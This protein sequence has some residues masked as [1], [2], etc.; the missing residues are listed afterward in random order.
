[1]AAGP[2]GGDIVSVE[3]TETRRSASGCRSTPPRRVPPTG[4]RCAI[5]AR[6]LWRRQ[7]AAG[8]RL[9]DGEHP[10]APRPLAPWIAAAAARHAL[11]EAASDP[12]GAMVRVTGLRR[13]EWSRRLD[14]AAVRHHFPSRRATMPNY[15]KTAEAVAALTPEQYRVTQQSGTER[16]GSGAL[17]ST[18]S[19][20]STS[21]SCRANPCS[22]VRTS[23]SPAAAGRASP[24]RS[25]RPT[26]PNCATPLGMVRTEVRSTHGDSHLGHV[27]DD[28]PRDRGGLRYCINSASLRFVPREDMEAAGL[29]RLSTDK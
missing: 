2:L 10:A 8:D 4:R 7:R 13:H 18:S 24:G 9:R 21:T 26:W 29:R 28:G 19:P 25:S 3:P 22:P 20:A 16:P 14:M 1:M 11:S 27:F 12:H 15:E 17:L 5:A 6:R 23:T